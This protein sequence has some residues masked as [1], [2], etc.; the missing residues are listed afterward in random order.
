M[1]AWRVLCYVRLE[2]ILLAELS[3]AIIFVGA[4]FSGVEVGVGG[5][6]FEKFSH[7]TQKHQQKVFKILLITQILQ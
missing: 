6:H 7:V 5:C 4:E 2:S 3:F 1:F